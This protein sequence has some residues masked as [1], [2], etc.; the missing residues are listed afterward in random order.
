MIERQL[1]WGIL[2]CAAIAKRAVI[3]G[4][5]ES[6]TGRL[7]AIAS[8]DGNKAQETAASFDIPKSYASY[9]ALLADDEIEAVYIPLPNHLHMEWTI[10]AAQAGKHVLCEKPLA[11]TAAEAETMAAACERA[12]VRLSEAFMYRYNPRFELI[13]EVLRSGE[14]GEI[15]GIHGTFTFNSAGSRNN[16]RFRQ[17]WGGG[18]IYDIGCYPIS[19]ARLLLEREPE[20]AAVHALFS[21]EHGGVDMVASGMLEFGGG[22][23]LTFECAMWAAPRNALEILGT[24]GR[25]ELLPAFGGHDFTVTTK[26]DVRVVETPAVNQYALQADRFAEEVRGATPLFPSSDAVC[27]MRVIDACLK[28]ARERARIVIN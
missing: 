20:A 7:A 26:S 10:K 17:E 4:I 14:I 28:S 19:A 15:R 21:P 16:F 2:G 12:G 18:S 11:L 24:D 6:R 23:A 3:P 9:D 25:I 1:N 13:K 5:R 27:N 22:V 8:R